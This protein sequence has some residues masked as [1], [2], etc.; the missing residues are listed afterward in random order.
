MKKLITIISGGLILLSTSFKAPVSVAK[1]KLTQQD[2]GEWVSDDCFKGIDYRTRRGDFN[3]N[4]N[5]WMWYAQIRN[6]YDEKINISFIIT[7]PGEIKSPDHRTTINGQSIE[8]FGINAFITS[9]ERC[10]VRVGY[11]RF[12]DNDSGPYYRCDK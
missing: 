11:I 3:D 1:T 10:H 9:G 7:D 5:K 12:G 4:L 2:W 8:G 6:R